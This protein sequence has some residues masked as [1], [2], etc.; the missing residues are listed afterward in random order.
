MLDFTVRA[1]TWV[2]SVCMLSPRGRHR[3]ESV[4]A[5]PAPV[6]RVT[7]SPRPPCLTECLGGSPNATARPRASTLTHASA[8]TLEERHRRRA[9]RGLRER[10]RALYLASLGF[11]TEPPVSARAQGPAGHAVAAR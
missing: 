10:R 6:T 4:P 7:T 3:A 1:L 9:T 2:L 5:S 8:L 11:D